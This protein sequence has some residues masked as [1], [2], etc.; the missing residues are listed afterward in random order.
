[1]LHKKALIN[2]I[3]PKKIDRERG[4][5][6]KIIGG[7]IDDKLL[8]VEEIT[9]LAT[10]PSLDEIRSKMIGLLMAGPTKLVRTIKE[11][12]SRM[13]RILATKN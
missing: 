2:C 12:S 8:S 5:K 6:I 9:K 4:K 11:P 10:L 3:T 1:M 13:A 7:G